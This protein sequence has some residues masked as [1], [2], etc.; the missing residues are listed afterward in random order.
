MPE[1]RYDFL[2]GHWVIIAE[3]RANRPNQFDVAQDNA[4]ISVQ[5]RENTSSEN[6]VFFSFC[7]FC[8]GN[9]TETPSEVAAFREQNSEKN[10]QNWKTRVVPNR[11]PAI[12]ENFS[13][14]ISFQEKYKEKVNFSI[15]ANHEKFFDGYGKHEVIIETPRHLKSFSQFNGGEI[16]NAFL[17]YR[18]RLQELRTENKWAYILIFKN[19]GAAAGASLPHTHSQLTAMPFVPPSILTELQ[20]AVSYQKTH[21]QCYWCNLIQKEKSNASCSDTNNYDKSKNRIVTETEN[22]LTICPF[23]SRFS[24]EMSILPKRHISHFETL[25]DILLKELAFLVRDCVVQLEKIEKWGKNEPAY[26]MIL[27]SAPFEIISPITNFS[28]FPPP[29]NLPIENF[30]HFQISILPSLAK[31]AGFEWGT[32]IHINSFS[33]ET[34][35]EIL[36]KCRNS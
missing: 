3:E 6:G 2:S 20:N 25:D 1:Y 36:R 33:P 32:G 24:L 30:Y 28:N 4:K 35:A 29:E 14:N 9:E 12:N 22:F 15:S 11:Y 7:P 19:V 13:D 17:M 34:A 5:N 23:A 8:P 31:A 18:Q 16:C 21:H 10:S 27:K 26:N